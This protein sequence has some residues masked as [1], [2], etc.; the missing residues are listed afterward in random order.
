MSF[1]AVPAYELE[2]ARRDRKGTA[3]VGDQGRSEPV[4]DP[5]PHLGGAFLVSV[6]LVG[7]SA[8]ASSQARALRLQRSSASRRSRRRSRRRSSSM[9]RQ[10]RL[11][12]RAF[13]F[14]WLGRRA[15]A[16][17]S[18]GFARESRCSSSTQRVSL[19][20][21]SL[22]TAPGGI[23][24]ERCGS[25]PAPCRLRRARR[26]RLGRVRLAVPPSYRY[27][28]NAYT[29]RQHHGFFGIGVPTLGGLK[30]VLV[31]TRGPA[32]FLARPR[33]CG[34]RAVAALAARGP[35]GGGARVDRGRPLPLLERRLLPRLRRRDARAAVLRA[36]AAVSRARPSLRA[37]ALAAS[38]AR[39]RS[40]LG[41]AHDRRFAQLGRA[42]L[43]DTPWFPTRN[44]ISKTIWAWVVPDRNVGALLVLAR[45]LAAVSVGGRRRGA[46]VN[47]SSR[48]PEPRSSCCAASSRAAGCSTITATATWGSTPLRARDDVG[49]LAVSRLLR[50]VPVLAQ[51]L[52]FVVRLLPGPFVTS[53]KWTMARAARLRSCCS[54][55][56][57]RGSFVRSSSPAG[58]VAVSPLIVGPVFLNTY[59]LFPALLTIAAVLAFLRDRERTAYVL[60]A[61]R[62][63][64][65]C[66]P[67]VLLP[68][69]LIE[70]WERGGR[71]AVRRASRGSAAYSC[72]C[73]SRSP[74]W[75]PADCGSATGCSFKRGLEVESLG[76]SILLVLHRLGLYSVTLRDTR[77]ARET[78]SARSRTRSR[79]SRRS[80]SSQRCST[81]PGSTCAAVATASSR[82][83]PR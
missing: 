3:A 7:D 32:L 56:A 49:P 26:V 54:S 65:R 29:E 22:R 82:A 18:Q 33:C 69:A 64:R 51:P 81:S 24:G 11:R 28:A 48:S 25:S 10:V 71:D 47:V 2:R 8:S 38:D 35:C 55:V 42:A 6:F 31:G 40:R 52:F 39:A 62:S 79:S 74:S 19:R 20:S 14:A 72:W 83:R 80:P 5:R 1:L 36:G 12:S 76:G 27:V 63:P 17:H 53:F 68:L 4:A 23:A 70:T 66:I 59:D 16:M 57:M 46:P 15:R 30:D 45:A 13:A 34:R 44:E 77:P 43:P 50:R 60:L 73:I 9:T 61:S 75:G 21:P 78:P 37:G 58:V 67:L 41:S